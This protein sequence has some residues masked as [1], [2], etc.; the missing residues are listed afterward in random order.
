MEIQDALDLFEQYIIAEKG[1]SQ[2][3]LKSYKE[4][5]KQFFVYFNFKPMVEDLAGED[6]IEFLRYEL[7]IG[8]S[9]STALRRLSST[10]SFYVFLKREGYVDF[11]IPEIES[12][13]KPLHLPNCLS[14]EEVE[15]LLDMPDVEKPEGL[16]D[17]A[18]LETM[19]ASGLR[20]S[21]LLSLERSRV[22]LKKSIVTIFGKGAKERK[23]PLGDFAIEYI[24]KYLDHVRYK[25]P[26][27]DTK[28]LFLNRY[29]KPLSRQYFFK[30][31]KKYAEMAGITTPISPHTLRHCFATHLIENHAQLR[32]VQELLGHENIATTQIYTH[33]STK[34]ILSAYDLYMRKK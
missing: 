21:E 18:M 28:Y 3:T 29:G 15:M 7:S 25:N 4:D 11:E 32:T 34:R 14:T 33:I 22:N 16:R 8:M 13:K 19:Y 27:H 26:G 31:I 20:V 17:R 12:P 10:K 30:Q 24:A 6:L 2:Q 23:V 1:L 9:I 5:L